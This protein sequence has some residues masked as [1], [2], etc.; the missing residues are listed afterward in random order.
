MAELGVV[1]EAFVRIRADLRGFSE[2]LNQG[3]K[4]SLRSVE[5]LGAGT[6]LTR[7]TAQLDRFGAASTR[8]GEQAVAASRR[9]RT[10]Q[11]QTARDSVAA[12]VAQ[13]RALEQELVGYRQVAAA[14]KAGSVTQIEANRLAASSARALGLELTNV[15]RQAVVA[16][17]GL[18]K[19]ERGAIAGSGAFRGMGRSVAFAS[20]S[21]IGAYGLVGA[22]R[23]SIE[24]ASDLDNQ[25]VRSTTVFREGAPEIQHWADTAAK[26][27]GLAKE[28]ALETGNAFGT[29][30][31]AAGLTGTQAATFS[32]DLAKVSAAISLAAGQQ[33]PSRATAALRVA[34]AGRGRALRQYG[35]ILDETSIKAKALDLGILKP[36][37][38]PTKILLAQRRLDEAIAT[39]QVTRAKPGA[40]LLDVAK[41]DDAVTAAQ[42]KLKTTL[43][44]T[45]GTLTLQ[46][47]AVAAHAIIME[48]GA[49]F[50]ARYGESLDTA[51]GRSRRFHEG[52]D[53]VKEE[54]GQALF[55]SFTKAVEGIN[56]YI[57]SLTE[58]GSRHKEFEQ[59]LEVVSRVANDLYQG[60]R[61][62]GTAFTTLS[63]AVG[64]V[65]N[66]VEI[67]G[68][69]YLA[70]QALK[71]AGAVR[72]SRLALLLLGEQAPVTAAA[73]VAAEGEMAAGAAAAATAGGGILGGLFAGGLLSKLK[74]APLALLTLAQQGEQLRFPGAEPPDV[75]R[76]DSVKLQDGWYQFG[77]N[78][79]LHWN[80]GK[81]TFDKDAAHLPESEFRGAPS[82]EDIRPGALTPT[83]GEQAAT[84]AAAAES[85][86]QRALRISELRKL[87]AS[88][89]SSLATTRSEIRDLDTQISQ[90]VADNARAM[91]DAVKQ[92]ADAELAAI[93]QAKS[94]LTSLGSDLASK[95]NELLDAKGTSD[96]VD[97]N[98]P[99][100]KR[101]KHIQELIRTGGAT[102]ELIQEAK[103]VQAEL[104]SASSGDTGDRKDRIQRRLADLTVM[105]DEGKIGVAKFNR[106]VAAL[107][108]A[109]G[110]TYRAA[111]KSLGFAFAEGFRETLKELREQVNA[112]AATPAGLRGKATGLEGTVVRPVDVIRE[113]NRNIANTAEQQR[114][115]LY[116]LTSRR[117]EL[118][119]KEQT[120]AHR[121]ARLQGRELLSAVRHPRSGGRAP[122]APSPED[123]R[124]GTTNE[125][126]PAGKKPTHDL[127]GE[128][129][130]AVQDLSTKEQTAERRQLVAARATQ[131]EVGHGNDVARSQRA[132]LI[133]E[134]AT[135]N[136]LL[137][138]LERETRTGN[139]TSRTIA[140]R[141]KP[142]PKPQRPGSRVA[143]TAREAGTNNLS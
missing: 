126:A 87:E 50:V 93:T 37:T 42:A 124:P 119:L 129:L 92:A 128:L 138:R 106:E 103:R 1:G 45:T 69:A 33:D 16:A 135:T 36:T 83:S 120:D 19:V 113:Q 97:P 2:D 14:A 31:T 6:G 20:L 89:K 114:R 66:L 125:R 12:S 78:K 58:G 137:R 74:A 134:G 46:Q 61:L 123:N 143:A 116:A 98:S 70:N 64:G 118:L 41:A 82:P 75:L 5:S 109:N 133:R 62:L 65:G 140:Q 29:I 13:R 110:I 63:T 53:Q 95:I 85:A 104:D 130:A 8:A 81:G 100:A 131:A 15:E 38:D 90:T 121:L 28:S 21:F 49:R 27:L 105:F 9:V 73:V 107:L 79:F 43:V 101:L 76:Q 52:I 86:R 67:L 111:G 88:V 141:L 54:L 71:F 32:E 99:L 23:S 30:F 60:L 80:A 3:V 47:K 57:E 117:H 10:A 44:G 35:I 102:P 51:A 72:E 59:D 108:R 17:G 115:A 4:K 34:L 7:A 25:T 11:E 40:S 22:I 68:F 139:A 39:A 122:N 26:G 48:Q 94:N 142:K 84:T 77:K 56:A 24:A 136:T 96:R 112:I 18:S 55:P 127:M 91:A 132:V